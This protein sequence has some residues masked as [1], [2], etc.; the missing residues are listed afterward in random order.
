MSCNAKSKRKTY[1]KCLNLC[2]LTMRRWIGDESVEIVPKFTK[3]Y[4]HFKLFRSKFKWNI[5]CHVKHFAHFVVFVSMFI[6]NF[7]WIVFC[8][9]F[10]WIWNSR[11]T[12]RL[13]VTFRIRRTRL[14]CVSYSISYIFCR[15]SFLSLFLHRYFSFSVAFTELK[16]LNFNLFAFTL[17]EAMKFP[18]RQMFSSTTTT[19]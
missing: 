17:T 12:H 5:R 13:R 18:A 7:R 10:L 19:K 15:F 14:L 8:F 16:W 3:I 6:A 2:S 4:I 11:W 1:L 9:S